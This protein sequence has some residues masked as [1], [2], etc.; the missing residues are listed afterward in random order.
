MATIDPVELGRLYDEHAAG[1]ALFAR[2]VLPSGQSEDVIQDVFIRLMAER[3]RPDNVKA[4]LYR[5]VRNASVSSLR[6]GRRRQRRERAQAEVMGEAFE[7]RPGDLIDARMAC[8]IL[9]SLD[10]AEREVVVL[11]IWAALTFQEIA[12][13]TTASVTTVFRRY[14]EGLAMIRKG[15]GSPCRNTNT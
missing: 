5:A 7:A 6:S 8:E 14:R 12:E 11:R 13:I 4:W 10:R 2:Q 15:L 1:L 9:S 3:K